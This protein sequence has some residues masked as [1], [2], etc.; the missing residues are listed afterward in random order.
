MAAVKKLDF[1]RRFKRIYLLNDRR[2]RNEALLGSTVKAACV[3]DADKR[4][5]LRIIH[6]CKPLS[7]RFCFRAA[8]SVIAAA[9]FG[10][11]REHEHERA[12]GILRAHNVDR[13]CIGPVEK[14]LCYDGDRFTTE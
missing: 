14:L 12:Q 13:I 4:F 3:C 11:D 7:L 6:I 2:R 10:V 8:L 9:F 1:K 5:K